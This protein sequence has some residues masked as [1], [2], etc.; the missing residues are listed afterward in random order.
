MY[1]KLVQWIGSN[2]C[3]LAGSVGDVLEAGQ[4]CASGQAVNVGLVV[5][6]IAVLGVIVMVINARRR[7]RRENYFR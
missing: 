3:N 6:G 7:Q 1:D 4:A 2:T 5:L